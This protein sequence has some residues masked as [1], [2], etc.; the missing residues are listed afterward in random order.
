MEYAIKSLDNQA[1]DQWSQL[2]LAMASVV[3][4]RYGIN[5]KSVVREGVRKYAA[6]LAHI[7][8]DELIRTGNKLNLKTVFANGFGFPCGDR[9][10]KE[11]IEHTEQ[12]LFINIISCPYATYWTNQ[13]AYELG[14]MFCEEFYP[15]LVHETTS[16]KAQINL[17]NTIMSG[18]DDYCRLSIYLRPA[19]L[20]PDQRAQC[21]AEFD[22][23]DTQPISEPSYTP[24]L[25]LQ[26]ELL[27]TAF[28]QSGKEKLGADCVTLIKDA[29]QNYINIRDETTAESI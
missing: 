29:A 2:Y 15:V 17:G 11:W 10:C 1:Q 19:N 21:F 24:D 23:S 22:I 5:G 18:F 8:K 3:V 28:V 12:T 26:K 13:N 14:R 20:A 6:A 4:K 7:R 9:A 27:Y 25:E 16:E